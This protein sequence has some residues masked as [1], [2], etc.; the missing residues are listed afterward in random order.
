MVELLFE[1]RMEVII[2]FYSC[3][4][5]EYVIV[6]IRF[7]VLKDGGKEFCCEFEATVVK[8]GN[9]RFSA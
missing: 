4:R 1:M 8:W 6:R 7:R 2:G 3:R 9:A 5:V